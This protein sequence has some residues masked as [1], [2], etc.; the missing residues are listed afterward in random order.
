MTTDMNKMTVTELCAGISSMQIAPGLDKEYTGESG[1]SKEYIDNAVWFN[2]PSGSIF[3]KFVPQDMT[4]ADIRTAFDFFGPINRIDVVLNKT[5]G[6]SYRMAFIHFDYWY[7]S[8]AS[9]E[10]R[11]NIV[12]YFPRPFQ[13]YSLTAMRELSITINTRPVPKTTYNVD[14]MSDMLQRLQEQFATTVE[15]QAKQIEELTE[16]VTELKRRQ[17]HSECDIG[18]IQYD[19]ESLENTVSILNGDLDEFTE[20]SDGTASDIQEIRAKVEKYNLDELARDMKAK[21]VEY[22]SMSR[23]FTRDIG[24]LCEIRNK[25]VPKIELIAKWMLKHPEGRKFLEENDTERLVL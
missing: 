7:S 6:S 24:E 25:V 19:F 21:Q 16:E 20:W 2:G 9:L 17:Q 8:P 12:H 14:Q 1:L 23:V 5:N 10:A 22:S 15:K 11:H 4:D 13:M 3:L 18:N